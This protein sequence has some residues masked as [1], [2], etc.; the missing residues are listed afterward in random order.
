MKKVNWS[1]TRGDFLLQAGKGYEGEQRGASWDSTTPHLTV[2]LIQIRTCLCVASLQGHCTIGEHMSYGSFMVVFIK[3]YSTPSCRF[4]YHFNGL[5][6]SLMK[7]LTHQP[8]KKKWFDELVHEVPDHHQN[9]EELGIFFK[10]LLPCV[11][12]HVSDWNVCLC[13]ILSSRNLIL[14]LAVIQF[15]WC[16]H[17]PLYLLEGNNRTSGSH[18]LT[19]KCSP[20]SAHTAHFKDN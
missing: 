9:T 18:T 3:R 19:P 1:P 5:L 17:A 4:P 6:A 13:G 16:N 20:P 2:A 12:K 11:F 8:F 14:A 15:Y 7:W 10:Q